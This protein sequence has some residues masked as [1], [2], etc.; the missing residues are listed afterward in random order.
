MPPRAAKKTPG[1]GSKRGARSARAT[2]KTQSQSKVAEEP[3]KVEEVPVEA[4][5]DVKIEEMR[6]EEKP[7]ELE[8]VTKLEVS[9]RSK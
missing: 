8:S 1:P 3:V 9:V 5:E 4:K 7:L 6:V 2:P